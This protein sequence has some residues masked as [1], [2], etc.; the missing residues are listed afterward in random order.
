M[1]FT[2]HSITLDI[3]ARDIS[4][5]ELQEIYKGIRKELR[6]IKSKPLNE[7]HL[8]LYQI[9]Q[10]KGGTPERGEK[11]TV[12]FWK[13]VMYKINEWNKREKQGYKDYTEWRA[14]KKAYREL[15]K[16]LGAQLS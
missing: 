2:S 7:R 15:I 16:K 6:G 14:V 1:G 5:R 3:N 10:E 11:G 4:F 12:E 9:V 8:K 13:S